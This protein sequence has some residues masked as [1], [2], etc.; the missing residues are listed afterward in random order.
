M[1][2]YK[3][4]KYKIK[5]LN[6][7]NKIKGGEGVPGFYLFK[8]NLTLRQRQLST[9]YKYT[10]NFKKTTFFKKKKIDSNFII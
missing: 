7:K 4:N 8:I 3:Y 9:L 5:Y 10:D 1:E 2:I 6:L